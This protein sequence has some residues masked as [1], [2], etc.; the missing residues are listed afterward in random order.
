[1]NDSQEEY[2]AQQREAASPRRAFSTFVERTHVRGR[3]IAGARNPSH[4]HDQQERIRISEIMAISSPKNPVEVGVPSMITKVILGG[5]A[6]VDC[7]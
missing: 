4:P 5:N 7:F 6:S 2:L 3:A 1:M